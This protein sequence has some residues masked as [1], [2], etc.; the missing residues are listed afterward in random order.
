MFINS[1]EFFTLFNNNF[2]CD[3]SVYDTRIIFT[4]VGYI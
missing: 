1:F 4:N 2:T 3:S